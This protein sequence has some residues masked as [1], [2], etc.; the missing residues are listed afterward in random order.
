MRERFLSMVLALTLILT[1]M[2]ATALADENVNG[3]L[4]LEVVDELHPGIG[5]I[6]DILPKSDIFGITSAKYDRSYYNQLD[7]TSKA[8]Y[9]AIYSS[10]LKDGPTIDQVTV[11]LTTIPEAEKTFNSVTVILKRDET[12]KYSM[13]CSE[14][15]AYRESAIEAAL[16]ALLYDHPEL[17]W[18]VNTPYRYGSSD[19]L[20][21][22]LT[23][24][25]Y[26]GYKDIPNGG[27]QSY[28]KDVE[29]TE[30][31]YYM[32]DQGYEYAT[33][34]PNGLV[35]SANKFY[36][37]TGNRTDITNAINRAKASIGDLSNKSDY[38]KVKT[39]YEW[40]C[41]NM[42]YA[43]YKQTD[44]LY[45][46][47]EAAKYHNGW[48][49]YQT[50]YSALV[51][52]VTVCAGYAKS[53]KLLCDAY[54]I[55]CAIV[56]GQSHG[57]NHAWNYV[58]VGDD[59]YAIDCTWADQSTYID[60]NYLL[61]G[62]A[63]FTDHTEGTLYE[64][65][66]FAYPELSAEDYRDPNAPASLELTYSPTTTAT[67]TVTKDDGTKITIPAF[68]V[69]EITALQTTAQKEITFTA[70]IKDNVGT[71]ITS[72]QVEW[73]LKNAQEGIT[74]TPD[75]NNTAILT[76]TN[77]A[78][79]EYDN[80]KG[81]VLTVTATCSTTAKEQM[82]LVFV[83][84]RTPKFI[85]IPEGDKSLN[86][87][88]SAVYTA[89]VYDQYGKE[90]T[91]Q[92]VTWTVNSADASASGVTV[93]NGTV[94]VAGNATPGN[95]T[96]T[97]TLGEANAS[98][99]ISVPQSGHTHNWSTDWSYNE[100]HHWHV[101]SGCTEIS[102]KAEHSWDAGTE[103][104]APTCTEVGIKTFTCRECQTTKT[105]SIPAAGHKFSTEWSKDNA[106]H[107]HVC[108]NTGCNEISGQ[109]AHIRDEGTESKV[110]TCTDPGMKTFA[111]T[112]CKQVIGTETIPAT[113]HK[114]D[115]GVETTA[116]TCTT[117]GVKT[118]TCSECGQT[119][120]EAIDATGHTAGTEWKKDDINHWHVC[121]K[122]NT[123]LDSTAHTKSTAITKEPNCTETGVKTISCAACG[124]STT[125]M[126]PASG[127]QWAATLEKDETGH[128]T[129]CEKC[130][131]IKD[132][133]THSFDNGVITTQP[134]YEAAG[135]K[136]YT[137][138]A[139]QYQKTEA[140]AKLEHHY[141]NVWSKDENKHWHACTDA[142]YTDLKADEASHSWNA[143]TVTTAPT[144]A[145]PGEKTFTC[146]VCGQTKIEPIAKLEHTYSSEWSKDN[147]NHWHAC[148]DMGFENLKKDEAAHNWDSGVETKPPSSD[149]DGIKTYTCTV[150][151]QT[152]TETIGA[153]GHNY[154]T[155]WTQSETEHWHACIDPG[156]DKV[157]AKATHTW[158]S[159]ITLEPTYD[160]AGS[161]TLTC[162]VCDYTKTEDIPKKEHTF[163]PLW[164][165][166]ASH[167]WHACT[168]DGCTEKG[169][170]DDH[171]WNDGTVT[172]EPTLE[173]AGEKT[174]TCTVC[175]RTKLE[176]LPQ[177]EHT[178]SGEWSKDN[179]YHWHA[180]TDVGYESLIKDKAAHTWDAGTVTT[181]PTAETEGVRTFTCTICG[182]T[183]TE[184]IGPLEHHYSTEWSKDDTHHWHACT[185]EGCQAVSE[186]LEHIWDSGV[187]TTEPTES[188][189]GVKTF[190]C[191]VCQKTRTE[192]VEPV[193]PGHSHTWATAWNSDSTHHWHN[194]T[195]AGC[196]TTDNSQKDGYAVH[197][198]DNDTDTNCNVCGYVRTITPSAEFT[199][200]LNANGG[201]V[202]PASLTTSSGRLTSLPIPTRSGYTFTGW[203]TSASGGTQ[204][205]STTVFTNNT[206]IYA[207]WSSNSGGSSGDSSGS[208]SSSGNSSSSA[209]TSIKVPVSG[210]NNSV[211]VSATVSGTTATVSKLNTSQ[212]DSVAGSDVRTGM[213]E[214]DLSGL[215]R[216]I[217]TVNLPADT[218][219][220]IAK[221]A[222]DDTNDTK[223][224]TI[225]LSAA[226]AS[227]DA[228]ALNE[229][230]KQ[231]GNQITLTIAPAKASAL[232][233]RQKETVGKAPVFDL[234]MKSGTKVITSFGNGSATV[235]LPYTLEKGQNPAGVVVY[236]LDSTGNIH[237][238]ET[239]YDVRTETAV[240]TTHH[241][242]LYL[243]GYDETKTAEENQKSQFTDV[244]PGTYY[245][246][247]VLWATANGVTGGTT[248][249]TFSPG[250][251]CT[252]A[253]M[254]TFLWRAAGS[255]EPK[256]VENPFADV[257]PNAYYYKAVLWAV[258]QGITAGT[259]AGLF[260][261][262]AVVTRAQTVTFLYRAA[263][264]PAVSGGTS[265]ADVNPGAYY[266]NAVQWAVSKGI[267]AGTSVAAFS[268]N[269]NCTRA[270]IVTF[271]YRA[272]AD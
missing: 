225:K 1:L 179:D 192:P 14:T 31:R 272:Q 237:A 203:Y 263:G 73:A 258:E 40:V 135:V 244:Q 202:S 209:S 259:S 86:P 106:N 28:T 184:S 191:S 50:P 212:L 229:I 170:Q 189:A 193:T 233:A 79:A 150:C 115:E 126:I 117:N 185:D 194:C 134:T 270:Q 87:N 66:N 114:W 260:S 223:G 254:A 196:P 10:G 248:A 145:A 257:Q 96:V 98:V 82:L 208:S 174:Y 2:P 81:P 26:P 65:Y 58:Q 246:D 63:N 21:N 15:Q 116:P 111:C 48:R 70:T 121:T 6:E 217:Q 52:G 37:N 171:S 3:L 55:P 182:Q 124:W 169:S 243:V 201:S 175:S 187:I 42:E 215:K 85:Q 166:D 62:S 143:G 9:D 224:L 266:S 271:L 152:K 148:T 164:S 71:E 19:S 93:S 103:T 172:V 77:S 109:A 11:D 239:V 220:E 16:G 157:S 108:T 255:P 226:E 238:C 221:A 22:Q 64:E 131:E 195:A 219:R 95:Y 67:G 256:S 160:A 34:A 210:D 54:N 247:A 104:T 136:T 264:S 119:R 268:P 133:T 235:S 12:G 140:V 123:A 176:T 213:V 80:D 61:K 267:T 97:A 43:H 162:T 32:S 173:S 41:N 118:F 137:C 222:N 155:D 44:S 147:D 89:N 218:L 39:L 74:L 230:Q 100:T 141:S 241:L 178:Y 84:G 180:C 269:A 112:E 25:L 76:I 234:T 167:H 231:S 138:A 92:A 153:T 113:G 177:L 8:V 23:E 94:S 56:T 240:F 30:L 107:W 139:C 216:T 36:A 142:G 245:Y 158:R 88:S 197:V 69:P 99:T 250:N 29:V 83:H 168:E 120:T 72:S 90:M 18:L 13:S 57:E 129:K 146:T 51:E 38:E 60:Y 207:Q 78:L 261:P 75:G 198:Y 5:S 68:T 205:T 236:Y 35:T 4:G 20:G 251:S 232:N 154:S 151:Q 49:G 204:V 130:S 132:K 200:T 183:R 101:C 265:F 47:D 46:E 102:D 91:E 105:E 227:F 59:W 24:E 7:T 249:T 190:T 110:P 159:E 144:Y 127:H 128:W 242:S 262:D 228:E 252:R 33:T 161:R 122:C 211:Q 188:S 199:V 53:F 156:C 27:A 181:E 186:R 163:S 253:Q 45:N 149:E 206:T 165:S 214:V 17:S 125:E